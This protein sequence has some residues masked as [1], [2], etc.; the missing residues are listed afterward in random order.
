MLH[1]LRRKSDAGQH[2]LTRQRRILFEHLLDRIAR[3][4]KFQHRARGDPRPANGG[5]SVANVGVDDDAVYD[6]TLL[7]YSACRNRL[8]AL[9]VS[10][11]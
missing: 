5:L 4:E 7:V 3:R 11:W 10:L 8:T 6:R 2:I 1:Q 9:R